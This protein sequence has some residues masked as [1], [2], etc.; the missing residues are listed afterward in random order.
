MD[1]FVPRVSGDL[2]TFVLFASY[3]CMYTEFDLNKSLSGF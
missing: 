1:L 2:L 3:P